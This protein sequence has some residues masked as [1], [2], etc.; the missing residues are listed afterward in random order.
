MPTGSDPSCLR[1][2]DPVMPEHEYLLGATARWTAAVRAREHARPDPLF[3]DPWAEALAGAEGRAWL[4][5]RAEGMVVPIILR[6]RYF[7][8]FLLHVTREEGVRQ[9]II[10][11]AGLDTRGY[12]LD[13][14]EGTRL[15]ELDR[16][17]VLEH[18]ERVLTDSRAAPT[19]DRRP[20]VA[21]LTLAWREALLAAGF[22]P[23]RPSGWLLEGFLFYLSDEDTTRILDE[24]SGLAAPQSRLGFDIINREVLTFPFTRAWVE[25]QAS[26]GAP[27]IGTMDDPVGFLAARGW[28]ARLTQ[29]SEPD[30]SH[31]RWT[32]PAIPVTM[33]GMP[34]NWLVTARKGT[35]I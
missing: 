27:W 4:E 21:D 20:V 7:D 22:D 28:Q 14:P 13:W 24:V 9:V 32:L 30:V 5:A 26:S 10:L 1:A 35:D 3:R 16:S 8:D 34:H 2:E 15:F 19:C 31:G 11:A 33:P 23:S 12:R 25:M 29:A 17:S 18:K 6:I